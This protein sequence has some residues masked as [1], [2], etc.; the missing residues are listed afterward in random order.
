MSI[1]RKIP[2][3]K[4]L[5]Q[6]VEKQFGK[7]MEVHTD[8]VKLVK[9]I[10]LQQREHIS[11]STLERVWGYST[12]G[13]DSVSLRTLNVLAV[14]AGYNGWQ[15]FCQYLQTTNSCDS[16]IFNFEYLSSDDLKPGDQLRIGWQPNR[17][18][19][20]EYL[21]EYKF[22]AIECQNSKMQPGDSFTCAQ[23]V[24]GKVLYLYNFTN[25]GESPSTQSYVVGMNHGLTTLELLSAEEIV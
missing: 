20:I 11:E 2:Q 15:T 14:Y 17:L 10:E 9:Q 5:C 7:T 21:G 13:Y 25:K 8:F 18:C 6:L 16:E 3:I 19:V 24:L 12:R 22:K 1:D 23:F 4:E